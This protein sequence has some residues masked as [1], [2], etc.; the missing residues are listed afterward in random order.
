MRKVGPLSGVELTLYIVSAVMV[1]GSSCLGWPLNC[2]VYC[3]WMENKLLS[4]Q[5]NELIKKSKIEILRCYHYL[6]KNG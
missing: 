4:D 3:H 1:K 6:E 5:L 2:F